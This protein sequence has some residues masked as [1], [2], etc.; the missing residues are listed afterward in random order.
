MARAADELLRIAGEMGSTRA[1]SEPDSAGLRFKEVTHQRAVHEAS[2]KTTRVI[3]KSLGV[4]TPAWPLPAS[5]AL[6]EAADA[7][8]KAE[9]AEP[10]SKKPRTRALPPWMAG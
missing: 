4:D 2:L 8:I 6:E 7:H 5:A 10:M 3:L 1:A 9:T